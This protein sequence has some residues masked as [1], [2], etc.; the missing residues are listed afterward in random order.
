MK[1]KITTFLVIFFLLT[2]G[3]DATSTVWSWV[4]DMYN[5]P[6]IKPQEEGSMKMFPI[7]SVTTEGLMITTDGTKHQR[8]TDPSWIISRN[9]PDL[10]PKNPY[11]ATADSIKKGKF[12]YNSYCIACHGENGNSQTPVA[13]FRGGVLPIG[14]LLTADSTITEGYLFYKITY[15]GIGDISMP[16]FAYSISEEER[17]HLVNYLKNKWK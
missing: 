16:P 13:L 17:W 11:K 8:A 9:N 14:L 5:Q 1:A 2:A 10:A 7:G 6:S 12:L 4:K 15:G 3:A